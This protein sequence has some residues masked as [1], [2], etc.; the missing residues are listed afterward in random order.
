MIDIKLPVFHDT[1]ENFPS[2][3]SVRSI[4]VRDRFYNACLGWIGRNPLLAWHRA[5]LGLLESSLEEELERQRRG[6]KLGGPKAAGYLSDDRFESLA[7][8]LESSVDALP[9][10]IAS[11]RSLMGGWTA[12]QDALGDRS[13][14]PENLGVEPA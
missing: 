3:P 9:Q 10:A 7:N 5:E 6:L 12:L 13:Y 11:Y 8:A 2:R 1:Y 14:N 4:G